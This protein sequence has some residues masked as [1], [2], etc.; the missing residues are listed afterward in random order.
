MKY[1][2]IFI[3]VISNSIGFG[4]AKEYSKE[5]L[6]DSITYYTTV[7]NI[8]GLSFTQLNDSETMKGWDKYEQ[9]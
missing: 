6:K 3:S 4:Q 7:A 5:L 1:I 9:L 8:P 2:F